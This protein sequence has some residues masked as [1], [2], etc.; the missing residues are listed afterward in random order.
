MQNDRQFNKELLDFLVER[1]G[2]KPLEFVIVIF[3]PGQYDHADVSSGANAANMEGNLTVMRSSANVLVNV[4]G[5]AAIRASREVA[6]GVTVN[7]PINPSK[8]N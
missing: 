5:D 3:Q 1:N 4:L 2:G 8:L 6:P 7:P